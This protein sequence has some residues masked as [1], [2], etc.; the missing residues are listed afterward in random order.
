MPATIAPR[1]GAFRTTVLFIWRH[2]L[3]GAPG[4][5]RFVKWQ[6]ATRVLGTSA[7]IV[8]WVD[9]TKL[10]VAPGAS[11]ATGNLYC[12]LHEY[13]DMALLLDVLRTDDLFVDVGANV[14]TYTILASGACGAK[15]V[16]F[17]PGAVAFHRLL[18]NLAVNNIADRVEAWQVG[19]GAR[20]GQLEFIA[21]SDTVNRIAEGAARADEKR[22]IIDL[23]TL[24]SALAD[25]GPTVMKID[26]EGWEVPVLEGASATLER[27]ELLLCIIE[28]NDAVES[29]G[30]SREDVH[31]VMR[32]FGFRPYTYVP[33]GRELLSGVD[34]DANNVL[35]IRDLDAVIE[36][37][38]NA[39]NRRVLGNAVR[40]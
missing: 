8:D 35:F 7:M 9:E 34:H 25:R 38:R 33:D 19:V 16:S 15:S 37:V 12:G 24:D 1:V 21:D 36:R 22:V 6:A 2:P 29:Y 31:E 13:S 17:E 3:G 14:G 23:V 20:A 4:L 27:P 18:E 5:A 30:Y 26:V 39:P 32:G 10:V 28:V 11:G 40:V